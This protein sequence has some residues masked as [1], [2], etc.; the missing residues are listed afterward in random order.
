MLVNT[1]NLTRFEV[2]VAL[3]EYLLFNYFSILGE[4]KDNIKIF[5]M[6]TKELRFEKINTLL[7]NTP[8]SYDGRLSIGSDNFGI[9]TQD[10]LGR[11]IYPLN[12]WFMINLIDVG[13]QNI[14]INNRCFD[15]NFFD[16][17]FES[18]YGL[19]DP[20]LF[21]GKCFKYPA[22]ANHA[23]IAVNLALEQTPSNI[24]QEMPTS[25]VM[26]QT[27][28]QNSQSQSTESS[29]STSISSGN[30]R[31]PNKKSFM[32]SFLSGW[33]F[34]NNWG[35]LPV[36]VG[37]ENQLQQPQFSPIKKRRLPF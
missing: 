28:S 9:T 20:G 5:L 31:S 6:Q 7:L 10:F 29:G 32:P 25:P 13:N 4:T 34:C 24:Y 18:Q 22:R 8:L 16:N 14:P 1:Y 35:N 21:L 12:F 37:P 17:L 30:S 11:Q 36:Q 23:Q 33:P 26:R 27:T 2:I 15:S 19:V 3:H